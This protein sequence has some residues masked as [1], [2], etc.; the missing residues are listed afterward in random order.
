MIPKLSF[1]LHANQPIAATRN[2]CPAVGS[3]VSRRDSRRQAM[4]LHVAAVMAVVAFALGACSEAG[5]GHAG[6]TVLGYPAPLSEP[7]AT[8]S[9]PAAAHD[10][11]PIPSTANHLAPGTD[12]QAALAADA[13]AAAAATR[14]RAVSA[15]RDRGSRLTFVQASGHSA[16]DPTK[17]TPLLGRR[18]GPLA[19][20]RGG[21]RRCLPQGRQVNPRFSARA[22]ALASHAADRVFPESSRP[23]A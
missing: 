1:R 9:A 19:W 17:E 18:R 5:S 4:K 3:S 6:T 16:K 12:A 21:G 11:G 10:Y 15:R 14:P 20:A 8:L 22:G 2:R 7:A 13:Q 23:A